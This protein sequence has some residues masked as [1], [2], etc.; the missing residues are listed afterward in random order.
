MSNW[1]YQWYHSDG[2]FTVDEIGD[3]F[4]DYAYR[5]LRP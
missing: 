5:G 3:A 4:W 2:K 1:A